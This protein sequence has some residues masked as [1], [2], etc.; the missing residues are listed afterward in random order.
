MQEDLTPRRM[1]LMSR[2]IEKTSLKNVWTNNGKIYINFKGRINILKSEKDFDRMDAYVRDVN[3]SPVNTV[4]IFSVDN[5]NR[6][7]GEKEATGFFKL[8]HQNICSLRKNWNELEILLNQMHCKYV[9]YCKAVQIN[10]TL[11]DNKNI[12]ITSLYRSPSANEEV[13]VYALRKYLDEIVKGGVFAHILV[14]DMNIKINTESDCVHNYLN[15][16]S[17]YNFVSMINKK[18]RVQGDTS[19]CLDHI[20]LKSNLPEYE[21]SCISIVF[22]NYITDHRATILDQFNTQS[23]RNVHYIQYNKL[24]NDLQNYDWK[25][26]YEKTEPDDL[27]NEI[28]DA[29]KKSVQKN[30]YIKRLKRNEIKRKQWI[31]RGIVKS[32]TEKNKLYSE[33]KAER[34]YENKIKYLD[35]KRTLDK[36]I[37]RAKY[38]YYVKQ[39]NRYGNNSKNL[40]KIVKGISVTE[41]KSLPKE[42]LTKDNLLCNIS[43]DI[44]EAFNEFFTSVGESYAGNKD[45]VEYLLSK[46]ADPFVKDSDGKTALHKAA[47]NGHLHVCRILL[48][49]AEKLKDIEDNRGN[50]ANVDSILL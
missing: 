12:F 13:F 21:H 17:E 37:K 16:L 46:D 35:Y 31:T 36:I 43:R 11:K 41:N 26:F 8:Y 10:I 25:H 18:T 34:S 24:R 33:F 7:W 49:V 2:A 23:I 15:T 30:T 47:E 6:Y 40:W 44:A 29:L 9:G 19:N 48:S 1:K 27:A 4:E 5:H 38:D 32:V 14:G 20:F 39:I 50:K 45:I 42:I 28:I 22:E 3:Y